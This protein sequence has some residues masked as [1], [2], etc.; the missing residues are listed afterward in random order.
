MGRGS[1]YRICRRLC[2]WNRGSEAR[3][4][5]VPGSE[6]RGRKSAKA[7]FSSY[8]SK[9]KVPD[10][11][12]DSPRPRTSDRG[13]RVAELLAPEIGYDAAAAIAKES[14]QTGRTVREVTLEKGV[15]SPARLKELLDPRGMTEPG[16]AARKPDKKAAKKKAKSKR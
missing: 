6:V 7:V 13:Q 5:E 9:P 16:I 12:P 15:V 10:S 1:R 3:K 8:Y 4:S 11:Y 2:F 14:H